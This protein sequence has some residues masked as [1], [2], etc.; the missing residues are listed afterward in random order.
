MTLL[1]SVA[2]S[3]GSGASQDSVDRR[4][5]VPPII[6]GLDLGFNLDHE[7]ASAVFR[8]AIAEDPTN[9]TGYRL[10]AANAWI[11]LLFRQGAIT[12]DDYLGQARARLSRQ[13]TEPETRAAFH[14]TLREALAVA[15]GRLR[16]DPSDLD[17]RYEVGAA[18]GCLASYTA[19]IE[20]RLLDS[21][22]PARRAYREHQR[23][24]ELDPRRK[25]AGLVV[26]TYRYAVS[27]LP[28]PLRLFARI[29][30]VGG[31]RQR[32]LRMVE[33]AARH[34]SDAQPSA[35]FVLVLM[36][37]RERRYDD[38][39]RVIQG[40][41]EQFPRNRLLWLEE[42]H[43]WL[44]AG[45]PAEARAAV[46]EG[47]VRFA[48]DPRPRASGEDARWRYAHGAALLAL[49]DRRA[50]EPELRA[51]LEG[52]TRDWVAG[53][54]HKELGTLAGLDG[55]RA[56]ALAEYRLAEGLCRRDRDDECANEA[57]ALMRTVRDRKGGS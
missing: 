42:A 14:R 40:L 51:A 5:P 34:R 50:A 2:L 37:T 9:P 56:R 15:E 43:T 41:R 38:A 17:A 13:T 30:G 39:I 26:G 46:V 29:A 33:E 27:S 19:T 55:D 54:A 12:V 18:Y 3:S 1:M 4:H 20:G 28:A 24:L 25:E 47:L 44:R 6:Q 23:V 36:Y 32:G 10:W 52:A 49:G 22:R 21:L 8:S 53:R 35:R 11:G 7:E 48:S 31:D 57:K 16:R 45:R